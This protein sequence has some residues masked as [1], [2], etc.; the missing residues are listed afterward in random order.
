MILIWQIAQSHT[1][2]GE[3]PKHKRAFPDDITRDDV[4]SCLPLTNGDGHWPL[5]DGIDEYIC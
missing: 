5:T 4:S 1:Q 2:F 3:F